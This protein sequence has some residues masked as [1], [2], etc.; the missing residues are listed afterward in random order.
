MYLGLA[1]VSDPSLP[2]RI[3]SKPDMGV[4]FT[5]LLLPIA[6]GVG[7]GESMEGIDVGGAARGLA[8]KKP[9]MVPGFASGLNCW[10]DRCLGLCERLG[11]DCSVVGWM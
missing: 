8:S 1:P 11:V 5:K 7:R 2:G 6:P 10:L 4:V 3:W 9:G